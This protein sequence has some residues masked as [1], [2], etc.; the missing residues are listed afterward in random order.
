MCGGS[1]CR[2]YL[3][4]FLNIRWKWNNLVSLR[5]NC[6]IFM[7]YLKTGGGGGEWFKRLFK[8]RPQDPH[9]WGDNACID[10]KVD[11]HSTT[12]LIWSALNA[13]FKGISI[14]NKLNH[15]DSGGFHLNFERTIFFKLAMHIFYSSYK[16]PQV[17][18]LIKNIVW[19]KDACTVRTN[20]T[21]S[22]DRKKG[23]V[24]CNL[25]EISWSSEK[26]AGWSALL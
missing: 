19:I 9:H 21:N 22:E 7:E 17:Y 12:H 26:C 15:I 25:R 23:I 18:E 13:C 8:K 20:K 2:Y 1:L 24:C 11:P 16:F 5:P 6:F 3:F 14:L 10:R 4:L